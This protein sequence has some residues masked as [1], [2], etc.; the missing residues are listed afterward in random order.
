MT[1]EEIIKYHDLFTDIYEERKD[2]TYGSEINPIPDDV[3]LTVYLYNPRSGKEGYIYNMHKSDMGIDILIARK[4][5]LQSDLDEA[6]K[7]VG[8]K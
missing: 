1:A 6:V 5:I 2:G 3:A 8:K 4:W 7:Q